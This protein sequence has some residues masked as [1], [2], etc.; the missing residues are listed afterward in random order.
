MNSFAVYFR[1][2]NPLVS[3]AEIYLPLAMMGNLELQEADLDVDLIID[4]HEMFQQPTST[5]R[6]LV[7]RYII[8]TIHV[9]HGCMFPLSWGALD[10]NEK[11]TFSDCAFR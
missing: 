9:K 7:Y 2:T 3:T 10:K 5:L 4:S 1:C 6:N 11:P 8:F